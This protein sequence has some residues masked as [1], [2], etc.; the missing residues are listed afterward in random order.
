MSHFSLENGVRVV[1]KRYRRGGLL[2]KVPTLKEYHTSFS[3]MYRSFGEL[4]ALDLLRGA[5]VRVPRPIAASVQRLVPPFY[6]AALATEELSGTKNLLQCLDQLTP[7]LASAIGREARKSID[8]GILPVDLH[9]GNV[10]VS[11]VGEFWLIDFDKART[12]YQIEGACR[13]LTDRWARSVV[14]HGLGEALTKA[15]EEGVRAA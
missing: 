14:K 15:F 13:L 6:S 5:G 12:R 10:L 3:R 1:L 11:E 7:E 2:G 8:V 4:E 9:L